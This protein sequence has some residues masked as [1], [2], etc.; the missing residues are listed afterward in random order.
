MLPPIHAQAAAW[1]LFH[2]ISVSLLFNASDSES[3]LLLTFTIIPF[4][5]EHYFP[6]HLLYTNSSLD[7]QIIEELSILSQGLKYE[8]VMIKEVIQT[9]TKLETAQ[10]GSL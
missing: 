1:T 2:A 8:S 6:L 5:L 9:F 10:A 3:N 7:G 4:P